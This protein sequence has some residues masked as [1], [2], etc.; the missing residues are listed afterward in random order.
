MSTNTV[1]VAILGGGLLG[2]SAGY[3]LA[4]AGRSVLVIDAL[5]PGTATNAGA[6][7][8]DTHVIVAV[9]VAQLL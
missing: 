9:G 2:W 3:R 7:V 6:G 4:R 5:E 1:E 8:I